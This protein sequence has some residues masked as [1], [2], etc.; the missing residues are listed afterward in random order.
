MH[1]TDGTV[2]PNRRPPDSGHSEWALTMSKWTDGHWSVRL[3]FRSRAGSQL[4]RRWAGE[5]G[6]MTAPVLEDIFASLLA[7]ARGSFGVLPSGLVSLPG[8]W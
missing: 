4:V 1:E 6:E 2:E 5:K 3:I 7:E 8:V